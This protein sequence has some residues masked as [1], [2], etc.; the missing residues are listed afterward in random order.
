MDVVTYALLKKH[1]QNS[2]DSGSISAG[3]S[4]YQIAV[5]NGF[6]GTES[7]WLASLKGTDAT[8]EIGENGNWIINGVDSGISAT[9][10][11]SMEKIDDESIRNLFGCNAEGGT[12]HLCDCAGAFDALDDSTIKTLFN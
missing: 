8:I 5:E 2:I 3:K 4:A 11:D 12:G 6:V 10:S 1:I 9:G 7:E